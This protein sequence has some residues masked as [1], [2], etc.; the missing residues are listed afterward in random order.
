MLSVKNGTV[1]VGLCAALLCFGT[2]RSDADSHGKVRAIDDIE[3]APATNLSAALQADSILLTW[4]A[5]DDDGAV[6]STFGGQ[7]VYRNLVHGYRVYRSIDGDAPVEIGS[8]GPGVTEY[9][10][11][12]ITDAGG[13]YVYDVRAF[14]SDNEAMLGIEP[15]SAEDIARTVTPVPLPRDVDGNLVF[16]WFSYEGDQV[17]L[18]DFFLLTGSFG[19]REDAE[20]FDPVYDLDGNGVIDIGDFFLFAESFSKAIANAAEVQEFIAEA[21]TPQAINDA[22]VFRIK[23]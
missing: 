3:P 13:L 15:G 20:G 2:V 14:D 8:T 11:Q 5:S 12:D 18:D 10:D 1:A 16:G 23:D 4:T 17:G 21:G 7:Y 19:Q 9:T 22:L 6:P